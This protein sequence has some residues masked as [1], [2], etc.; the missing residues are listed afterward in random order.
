MKEFKESTKES[1]L[2]FINAAEL[3]FPTE[4]EFQRFYAQDTIYDSCSMYEEMTQQFG[5]SYEIDNEEVYEHFKHIASEQFEKSR[6]EMEHIV[7]DKSDLINS[8]VIENR[9]F[10][11]QHKTTF[12]YCSFEMSKSIL[13]GLDYDFEEFDIDSENRFYTVIAFQSNNTLF[14]KYE[15]NVFTKDELLEYLKVEEGHS[16]EHYDETF[17]EEA[18]NKAID[19]AIA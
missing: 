1:N 16:D 6:K 18:F 8:T 12:E 14:F 19:E 11:K 17:F 15:D 2:Y 5:V 10:G 13:E 9:N 7:F 3:D 4:K